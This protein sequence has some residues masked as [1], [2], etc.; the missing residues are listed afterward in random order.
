MSEIVSAVPTA[1]QTDGSIPEAFFKDSSG[2]QYD[3]W[4]RDA[5][6]DDTSGALVLNSVDS[7][8][9]YHRFGAVIAASGEYVSVRVRTAFILDLS[10]IEFTDTGKTY[11]TYFN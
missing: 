9:S 7:R 8:Y 6:S 2:N 4:L 3:Y 5:Q 11:D 10:K 1:S